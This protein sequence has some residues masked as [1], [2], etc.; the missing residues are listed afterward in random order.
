MWEL[1]E[2]W[3]T[4]ILRAAIVYLA[5]LALIRF[6][7]KR[8]VGEFTPFDLV[9]LI[10]IGEAS[11][12]G[13]VGDDHSV[14]GALIAAASLIAL[15]FLFS[16]VTARVR[17]VERLVDGKPEVIAR[18]GRLLRDVLL[19]NNISTA[20]FDEVLR[21]EKCTLEKVAVALLEVDGEISVIKRGDE[22]PLPAS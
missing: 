2:A 14:L 21:R 1:Q 22:A 13:L 18:D 16:F 8:T 9:V 19:R 11:Q 20:E 15:N 6:S 17:P 3:W 4:I 10:L 12:N 5:L 7:G